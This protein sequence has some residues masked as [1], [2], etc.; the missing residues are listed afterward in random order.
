MTFE[1]GIIDTTIISDHSHLGGEEDP[2]VSY[3]RVVLFLGSSAVDGVDVYRVLCPYIWAVCVIGWL[4][5]I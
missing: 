2:L 3:V 1:L 4:Y 5:L